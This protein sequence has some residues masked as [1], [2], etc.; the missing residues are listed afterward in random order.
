MPQGATD[1]STVAPTAPRLGRRIKDAEHTMGCGERSDD[2]I[3]SQSRKPVA[4]G[5]YLFTGV[6]ATK[7]CF[8]EPPQTPP[9]SE[10]LLISKIA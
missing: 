6:I 1:P 2:A 10:D 5:K 3:R 8:T 9:S 7:E 4:V